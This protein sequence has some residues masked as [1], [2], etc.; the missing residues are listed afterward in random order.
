MT[1]RLSMRCSP[2]STVSPRLSPGF[3][4]RVVKRE[5]PQALSGKGA[6]T[7]RLS[8][9]RELI[10][11]NDCW[12]AVHAPTSRRFKAAHSDDPKAVAEARK[13]A[14][15]RTAMPGLTGRRGASTLKA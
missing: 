5:C 15:R 4:T 13:V 2:V 6:T 1:V 14:A 3:V 12:F 9:V 8:E 7:S 10:C 11:P